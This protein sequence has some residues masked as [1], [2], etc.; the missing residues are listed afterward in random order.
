MNV[1]FLTP[2][3]CSIKKNS[4]AVVIGH[5]DRIGDFNSMCVHAD[6]YVRLHMYT[7]IL[8]PLLVL[9][10]YGSI[11]IH[12]THDHRIRIDTMDGQPLRNI[13]ELL[14]DALYDID[15]NV[16]ILEQVVLSCRLNMHILT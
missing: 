12:G 14:D 9:A 10:D 13:D 8:A 15:H 3:E 4:S 5:L 11:I 16:N 1:L 7:E 6:M 2:A